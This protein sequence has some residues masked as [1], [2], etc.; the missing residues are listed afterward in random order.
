MHLSL[1]IIRNKLLTVQD[2]KSCWQQ[3]KRQKKTRKM[4]RLFP[5][6][7]VASLL[8]ILLIGGFYFQGKQS[9][10]SAHLILQEASINHKSKLQ[11]EFTSQELSALAKAM[12]K[13]DFPLLLPESMR[14]QFAVQG[15]RYCTLNGKLAA[16]V[17]LTNGGEA[18]SVSLFMTQNRKEFSQLADQSENID[19][20]QVS[21]WT[22]DGMFYVLAAN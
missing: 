17:K 11:L 14:Q 2:L 5:L 4:R 13:L 19:G 8:S 3:V 18:N 6:S 7:A 12:N 22:A 10:H 16:H 1:N 9:L 20:V 21:S 15:A